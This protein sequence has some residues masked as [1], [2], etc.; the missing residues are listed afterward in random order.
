MHPEPAAF[1]AADP[2]TAPDDDGSWVL[3]GIIGISLVAS[4]GAGLTGAL[5]AGTLHDFFMVAI[6]VAVFGAGATYYQRVRKDRRLARLFR[7]AAELLLLALS[8]GSLSYVSAALNRP[9]WDDVF[10]AWDHSLGFHWPDWLRR[11]NDHPNVHVV[12]AIAYH[13]MTPQLAL[14]L[15]ALLAVRN[16]RATD[17]YLIAFAL[18]AWICVTV[19]AFMPGLSPLVHFG[20]TPAEYPNIILAVPLEFANQVQALRSGALHITDLGGA[21]GL[22][23]FP[24]FHTSSA[25][26]LMLAFWQVPYV[27]WLGLLVNGTMLLAIPVEGSHYIVDV[28][29][30]IAVGLGSWQVA[31]AA[32]VFGTSPAKPCMLQLGAP[33]V[34]AE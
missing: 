7:S 11:V 5:Q 8:I 28:I 29:A 15:V 24:S 33:Q 18:S 23:T 10:A 25:V 26:I 3:W 31:K 16:Y 34:P 14:A 27:R 32:R 20:V 13:S 1:L 2:G 30:G 21:Q 22:V 19:S 17:V 9:L 12:L 6:A 4:I